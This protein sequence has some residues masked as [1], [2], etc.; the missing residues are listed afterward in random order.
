MA[1]SIG[2]VPNPENAAIGQMLKVPTNQDGFFLEAHVKLRP[3]D[4]AT[5]GVFM[6]GMSHSPKF[7]DE[8]DHPGQRRRFA[9]LH[10]SEP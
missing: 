3:V 10:G 5:D 6:C 9:R 1:L 8:T 2:V 7:S 4:F